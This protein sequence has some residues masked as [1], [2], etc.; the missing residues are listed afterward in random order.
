MR[1]DRDDDRILIQT[2]TIHDSMIDSVEEIIEDENQQ[3]PTDIIV[4]VRNDK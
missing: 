1:F 4:L 2:E 3:S